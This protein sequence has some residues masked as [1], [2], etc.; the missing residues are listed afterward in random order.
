MSTLQVKDADVSFAAVSAPGLV[1][2][3]FS[4]ADVP[5]LKITLWERSSK[6]KFLKRNT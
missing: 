2:S 5:Q 4:C 1:I 3:N 6:E